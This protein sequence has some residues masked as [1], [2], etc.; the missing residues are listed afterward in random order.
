MS[1][2]LKIGDPMPPFSGTTQ[3]GN[4]LSSEDFRGKK[5][6]IFFY[7]KASTPGCTAE[8]CNLN[9]NLEI[10]KKKGFHI[11]GISADSVKRQ[12]NFSDKYGF[13]YPLVAD[14][15]RKIIERFGVWGTKKFM[16]KEYKGILRTTFVVNEQGIIENIISKV[17]TKDHAN[18]ILENL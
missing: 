12:K 1:N 16:G 2:L 11:I 15:E 5:L 17:K 13:Q 14:E 7:P 9:S 3:A 18:Q 6:I 10:F 8:A 4:T